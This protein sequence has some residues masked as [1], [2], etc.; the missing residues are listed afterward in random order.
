M[1]PSGAFK[2]DRFD[3]TP[4]PDRPQTR[5]VRGVS[6]APARPGAE[7]LEPGAHDG[8]LERI[9]RELEETGEVGDR[10]LD[11]AL[12]DQRDAAVRVVRGAARVE[13]DRA[14]LVRDPSVDVAPLVSR[15]A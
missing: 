3:A 4:L 1:A 6:R 7:L 10:A 15:G 5:A 8:G 11:V 12:L 13:L 9:G 2:N 14:R